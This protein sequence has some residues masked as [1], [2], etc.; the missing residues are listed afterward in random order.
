MNRLFTFGCSGTHYARYPTWVHAIAD[1]FDHVENWGWP[2]IGNQAIFYSFMECHARNQITKNDTVMI[3]W[4]TFDRL[5]WYMKDEKKWGIFGSVFS[6]YALDF[7][8]QDWILE[9][10]NPRY[11]AIKDL[12]VI[13]GAIEILK[14]INCEYHI[15]SIW[16]FFNA[17]NYDK[18]I[19]EDMQ[20]MQDIFDVYYKVE[21]SL[22][23]S[24]YDIIFKGDYSNCPEIPK[25][26]GRIDYHAL[27]MESINYIQTVIPDRFIISDKTLAEFT[28][29]QA[30]IINHYE[31]KYTV[32][33]FADDIWFE[34]QEAKDYVNKLLPES[35]L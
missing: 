29:I 24:V 14:N 6:E 26:E 23:P 12:A 35:R 5:D 27:P 8:N 19:T 9:N 16:P 20:N 2:G 17:I 10:Y 33:P 11:F 34:D 3:M 18:N 21:E 31:A 4:S 15:M 30:K 7:Y 13:Y 28:Q 32:P 22:L 25:A 1:N